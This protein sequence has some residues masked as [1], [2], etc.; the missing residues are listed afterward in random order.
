VVAVKDME[1]PMPKRLIAIKKIEKA[2]QHKLFAKR[3]LRELKIL[4]LLAHENVRKNCFFMFFCKKSL[5][6]FDYHFAFA[7][8]QRGIR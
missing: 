2:F 3:T 7:K 5:D 8:I 4:R 1:A 6:C